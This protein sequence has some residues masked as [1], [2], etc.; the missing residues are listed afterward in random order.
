MPFFKMMLISF[1]FLPAFSVAQVPPPPPYDSLIIGDKVFYKV[2]VEASFPGGDAAWRAFLQK[3]LNASVPVDNG[4]PAGIYPVLV[5][6]IVSRDGTLSDIEAET[7]MGYGTEKEVI[8]L[9]KTSG[10]WKPARQSG[11][12][13]NA[14][15]RQPVTFLI[16]DED[17]EIETKSQFTFFTGKDN[18]LN[19]KVAKVN[20]SNLDVR[21]SKGTITKREDGKFNV[22]VTQ[23]GRVV[24]TVYNTKTEKVIEEIHFWAREE[25]S[26]K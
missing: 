7:N 19:V 11:R 26:T 20:T 3:N 22:R 18:E 8:R 10:L 21:V 14:Y 5:K 4:A 12:T 6:F 13:V 9:I 24:V 23:P 15:R 16:E 25:Y 2:E 17:V 1:C